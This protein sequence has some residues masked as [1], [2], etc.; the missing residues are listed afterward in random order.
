MPEPVRPPQQ[1]GFESGQLRLHGLLWLPAGSGPFPAVV[2]NHGS[3]GATAGVTAGMPIAEAAARLAPLFTQ[4]GFAFFYPFRRGQGA[5]ADVAPFMQDLLS[6][7]EQA[8]GKEARRHLQDTLMQTEQLDDVL[9]ALAFVRTV[10]EVDAQR[11]VVAGHSFGGQ[12]SIL[13]AARVPSLRAG[14]TFAAS[15]GSWPRSAEVRRV[16]PEAVRAAQCPLMFV[17]W[18]NDFST[19]ATTALA[20]EER[21]GGP[22][23]LGVLYPP[24][25]TTPEEG[26]SGLYL[27]PARWQPDVF[28][29]LEEALSH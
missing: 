16:L 17:Q 27:D 8:H 1:V 14:V 28:R 4:R 15:A 18:R 26:H 7:E 9:A 29:F 11:L 19:D 3:G 12:L 22:R 23:R 24:L 5:S 13:A 2:F 10:P 20:A 21:P 25:G 6:R